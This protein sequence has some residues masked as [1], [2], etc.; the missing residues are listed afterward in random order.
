MPCAVVID[1]DLRRCHRLAASVQACLRRQTEGWRVE[2]LP[3]YQ[4]TTFFYDVVI[5][6]V[7]HGLDEARCLRE[8]DRR[9]AMLLVAD[10]EEYVFAGY[11]LCAAD[12]LIRP[13]GSELLEQGLSN[14]LCKLKQNGIYIDLPAEGGTRREIISNILYIEKDGLNS[15]VHTFEREYRLLA[16][17]SVLNLPKY[18]FSYNGICVNLERVDQIADKSLLMGNLRL[19]IG[20][21]ARKELINSLPMVIGISAKSGLTAAEPRLDNRMEAKEDSEI[22]NQM[23]V[24]KEGTS[25]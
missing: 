5:V 20:R 3:S 9:M 18:F 1:K 25:C 24:R 6:S 4:K 14:A 11:D 16:P 15:R 7:D 23:R 21:K 10:T 22:M 2:I 8:W 19:P 17:L 13:V 12:Y